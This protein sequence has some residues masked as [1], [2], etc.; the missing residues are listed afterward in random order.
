MLDGS[1]SVARAG[2]QIDTYEWVLSNGKKVKGDSVK[3]TYEHAGMY[4]EELIVR[5]NKG[6]EDRDYIQVRVYEKERGKNVAY[7][8]VYHTPLRDIQA[9]QEVLFW[10]RLVNTIPPVMIDFG[11]GSPPVVIEK[12]TKHAYNKA[13]IYTVTYN[14]KGPEDEPIIAKM[15]V[16]VG[17]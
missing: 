1:R 10:N 16:V 15:K 12:E 6:A 13:G 2:E 14:A 4:T 9:G 17:K 5:T 11:D 7:G 3:L 8:W